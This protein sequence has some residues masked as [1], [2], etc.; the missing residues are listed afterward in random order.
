VLYWGGEGPKGGIQDEVF[1]NLLPVTSCCGMI[2]FKCILVASEGEEVGE[3]GEIAGIYE[4]RPLNQAEVD[5]QK[6]IDHRY[7]YTVHSLPLT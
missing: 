2:G 1:T 6:R 4:T 5:R 7:V 3:R